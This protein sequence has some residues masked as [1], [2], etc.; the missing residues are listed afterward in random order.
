VVTVSVSGYVQ[1]TC[2]RRRP[3]VLAAC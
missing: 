3:P 2:W 1:R